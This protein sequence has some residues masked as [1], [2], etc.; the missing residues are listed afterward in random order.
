MLGQVQS[1][2]ITA[3]SETKE[4]ITELTNL[5]REYI[6]AKNIHVNLMKGNNMLKKKIG[7]MDTAQK[8]LNSQIQEKNKSIQDLGESHK[9]KESELFKF[10]Q[11]NENF[12]LKI[13]DKDKKIS[14]MNAS[15]M[16]RQACNRA[17]EEKNA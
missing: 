10:L 6:G 14:E 5:K 12:E 1:Q 7:E 16:E 13:K 3:K 8:Q 17:I 11:E 4:K 15:E 2:L 9:S